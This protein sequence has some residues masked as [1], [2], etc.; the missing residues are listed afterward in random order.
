MKKR[1]DRVLAWGFVRDGR[2]VPRATDFK[3]SAHIDARGGERVVRVEIRLV[4]PKRRAK[5]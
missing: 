1:K 5:K 2:V 4:K 3:F